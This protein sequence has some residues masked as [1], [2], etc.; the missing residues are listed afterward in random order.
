MAIVHF[1]FK[2]N[3]VID[4][5]PFDSPCPPVVKRDM[6]GIMVTLI[7]LTDFKESEILSVPVEKE[8]PISTLPIW[9][10]KS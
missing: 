10:N 9:L 6:M 4:L 1:V 5:K 2:S 8:T 7:P 3:N